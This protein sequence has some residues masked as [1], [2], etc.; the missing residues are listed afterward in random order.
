[1][2]HAARDTWNRL[3]PFQARRTATARAAAPDHTEA[4]AW[5]MAGKGLTCLLYTLDPAG[6]RGRVDFGGVRDDN[7]Y[8]DD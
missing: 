1:M 4:V 7:I 6:E 8:D 3:F 5:R 2:A